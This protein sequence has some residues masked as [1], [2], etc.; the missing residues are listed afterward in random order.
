MHILFQ[1]ASCLVKLVCG[2]QGSKTPNAKITL[3]SLRSLAYEGSQ[4]PLCNECA[5][6]IPPRHGRLGEGMQAERALTRVHTIGDWLQL[7]TG[8]G[9]R[10]QDLVYK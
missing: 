6:P 4:H 8:N 10:L 3:A 9:Q 7:G 5:P 1:N 2:M